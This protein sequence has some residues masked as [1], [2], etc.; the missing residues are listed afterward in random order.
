MAHASRSEQ[1]RKNIDYFRRNR[2]R[3]QYTT[4][5]NNALCVSS[6]VAEAGCKDVI[7]ARLKRSGMHWSVD[8]ANAIIALRSYILSNRFDDFWYRR[9]TIN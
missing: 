9:T 3:M 5:Q 8:G 7:G 2:H 6:G 1:A 4:F